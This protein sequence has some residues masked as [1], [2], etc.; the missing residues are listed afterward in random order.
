VARLHRQR[1]YRLVDVGVSLSSSISTAGRFSRLGRLRHVGSRA[2]IACVSIPSCRGDG[3]TKARPP[4]WAR[5]SGSRRARE[6]AALTGREFTGATT[7]GTCAIC[8]RWLP[9]GTV[10]VGKKPDSITAGAFTGA[11]AGGALGLRHSTFFL[12]NRAGR[13]MTRGGRRRPPLSTQQLPRKLIATWRSRA[14]SLYRG[15]K[16]P[17]RVLDEI[18]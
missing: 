17:G 16:Y 5:R 11:C 3:S 15:V 8:P 9:G 18:A 1:H 10:V 13:R 12:R 7:A 6:S 4:A 2:F 14:I